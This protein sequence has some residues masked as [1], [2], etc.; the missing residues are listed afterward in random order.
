M[1]ITFFNILYIA[2]FVNRI[3]PDDEVSCLTICTMKLNQSAQ[4]I[5]TLY[6]RSFGS[7]ERSLLP[8]DTILRTYLTSLQLVIGTAWRR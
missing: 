3:M 6:A 1:D 4:K 2:S 5:C 8:K 7:L